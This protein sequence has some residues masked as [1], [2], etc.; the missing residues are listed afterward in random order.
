MK[1]G[2][3]TMKSLNFAIHILPL[4]IDASRRRW[5]KNRAA[6]L[7]RSSS[8]RYILMYFSRGHAIAWRQ[9]LI[10]R[11]EHLDDCS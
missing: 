6:P 1:G 8:S 3:M 5:C 2:Q 11:R 9:I 4:A 7:L 10:P